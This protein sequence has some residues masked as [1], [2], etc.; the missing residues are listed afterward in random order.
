MDSN[1][2]V[3]TRIADPCAMVIYGAAG[4]LTKRKLIPA[5]YNLATDGLLAKNFAVIGVAGETVENHDLRFHLE[6]PAENPHLR[7]T[8]DQSPAERVFSLIASRCWPERA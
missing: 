5:L 4:D 7:P 3:Q 8:L 1:P 2:D 6:E